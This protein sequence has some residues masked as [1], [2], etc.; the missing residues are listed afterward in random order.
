VL[1]SGASSYPVGISNKRRNETMISI[2]PPAKKVKQGHTCADILKAPSCGPIRHRLG[3]MEHGSMQR[4]GHKT[5]VQ[6]WNGPKIGCLGLCMLR[7]LRR[8]DLFQPDLGAM[9]HRSEH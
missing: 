7:D 3:A 1:V 8:G 5:T 2:A 6:P 4:F 9:E